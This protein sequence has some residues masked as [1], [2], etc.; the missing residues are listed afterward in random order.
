MLCVSFTLLVRSFDF[1]RP[2]VYDTRSCF[3]RG[4]P[5]LAIHY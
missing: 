5:S 3:L 1:V 2:Y 4:V